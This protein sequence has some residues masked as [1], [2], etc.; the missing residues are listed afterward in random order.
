MML[1]RGAGPPTSGLPIVRFILLFDGTV[2]AA[3]YPS[4]GKSS[5]HGRA[6]SALG[7]LACRGHAASGAMSQSVAMPTLTSLPSK[8]PQ[9]AGVHLQA[10]NQ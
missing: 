3:S 8:R 4:N 2:P 5:T 1:A 10:A 9:N 7:C 6:V